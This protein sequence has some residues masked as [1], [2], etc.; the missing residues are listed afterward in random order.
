ME[1]PTHF[2]NLHNLRKAFNTERVCV[3]HLEEKI[4]NN[5]PVCPH[6]GSQRFYNLKPTKTDTPLYKCA[7]KEC[8]KKFNVL[9]GTIFD[10]T[11]IPLTK[12]FEAIYVIT[13]HKKGISSIQLGKDIGVT[14]KTAWFLLHR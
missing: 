4:W 3:K 2:T 11:K 13:S 1:K 7:N 14:Q 8:H 12:W 6:C 9:S 5:Q 10:N